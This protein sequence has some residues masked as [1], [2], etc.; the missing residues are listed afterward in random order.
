MKLMTNI[1][2]DE[3]GKVNDAIAELEATASK[4]KA[5]LKLRNAGVYYG[6]LYSAEV[7]EYDREN[8]SAPLVRKYANLDFVKQVTV[9]QH[10]KAVVVEKLAV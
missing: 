10:V 8:I 6:A 2:V 3:L 9:T 5:E 4:L 7:Q 1:I